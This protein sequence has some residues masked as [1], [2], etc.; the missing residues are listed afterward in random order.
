[1]GVSSFYVDSED[2]NS[3]PYPCT[4]SDFDSWAISS[5]PQILTEKTCGIT[6]FMVVIKTKQE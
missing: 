3:D 6:S 1:M 5:V 2:E 4:A